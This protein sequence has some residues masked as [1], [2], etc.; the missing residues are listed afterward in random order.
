M[1]PWPWPWIGSYC[2]LSCITRHL[3]LHAK[4][5]WNQ[6]NCL[7]TDVRTYA[8]TDGRTD[9][10]D[11]FYYVDSVDQW[12]KNCSQVRIWPANGSRVILQHVAHTWQPGWRQL[13]QYNETKKTSWTI[14]IEENIS[15]TWSDCLL[16]NWNYNG[17][18]EFIPRLSHIIQCIG[19]VVATCRAKQQ[20]EVEDKQYHT[21]LADIFRF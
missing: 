9:I 6:R 4:F 1:W 13:R 20:T 21:I 19:N 15:F 5:H 16:G 8:R 14:P 7:W 3:Y 18:T 11:R 10:W 17:V 2:I 12:H